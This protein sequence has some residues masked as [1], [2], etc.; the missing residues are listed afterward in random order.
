MTKIAKCYCQKIPPCRFVGKLCPE[1][2]SIPA[3]WGE[4]FEKGFFEPLEKLLTPEFCADY[5]DTDAYIGLIR[6]QNGKNEYY[7]G[8]FLPE[9][10]SVPECYESMELPSQHAGICWVQGAEDGVYG[11]EKACR[12]EVTANGMQICSDSNGLFSY[13]ERYG[14]PRF[15]TPDENGEI[16]LDIGFFIEA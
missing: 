2:M 11:Q 13:F 14:C 10:S 8:M 3:F 1:G 9:N 4:C 5:P 7:I 6:P 15:T 12:Q 16:I